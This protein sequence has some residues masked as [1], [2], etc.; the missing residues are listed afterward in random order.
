MSPVFVDLDPTM[1]SVILPRPPK[2]HSLHDSPDLA[3]VRPLR[4]VDV[5]PGDRWVGRLD[6]ARFHDWRAPEGRLRGYWGYEFTAAPTEVEG[7]GSGSA[8]GREIRTRWHRTR[9]C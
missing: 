1:S 3:A 8:C 2:W 9:G 7:D 6:S 4:A 5:R